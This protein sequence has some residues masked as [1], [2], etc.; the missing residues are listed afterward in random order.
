MHTVDGMFVGKEADT[1]IT[2]RVPIMFLQIVRDYCK[3]QNLDVNEI[4][5]DLI[6]TE[7]TNRELK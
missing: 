4:L 1:Y 6:Q 2:I 7:W 5:T 3:S